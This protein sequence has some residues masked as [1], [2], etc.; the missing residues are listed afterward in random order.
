MG[1]ILYKTENILKGFGFANQFILQS[2]FEDTQFE[3]WVFENK[4]HIK[5]CF[6]S[7]L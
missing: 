2:K 1:H 6:S 3:T 7:T 4:Y 5:S